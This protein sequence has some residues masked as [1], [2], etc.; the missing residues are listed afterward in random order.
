M[1]KKPV[2][3]MVS[4]LCVGLALTGC[5]NASTQPDAPMVKA[6]N[7]VYRTPGALT[8]NSGGSGNMGA[9]TPGWNN[10]TNWNNTPSAN[11]N[12]AWAAGNPTSTTG[13]TATPN[14]GGVKPM[15]SMTTSHMPPSAPTIGTTAPPAPPAPSMMDRY[16]VQA[17][18]SVQ[19]TSNEIHDV[20]PPS[21]VLPAPPSVT[22]SAADM[23]PSPP[24]RFAPLASPPDR[25][26]PPP[27]PPPTS[28]QPTVDHSPMIAP[29]APAPVAPPSFEP[30]PP[31]AP[32][33]STPPVPLNL[34]DPSAPP[35]PLPGPTP[36]G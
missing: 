12:A 6:N 28:V 18:V 8:T 29:Q 19:P 35:P 30:P 2:L 16:P 5:R 13:P 4:A 17:G 3:G 24:D 15:D 20:A 7:S 1:G 11:Q 9:P 22:G 14:T 10:N 27:S 26:V 33:V 32:P 23:P 21:R 34:P 31:S 36:N 25:L